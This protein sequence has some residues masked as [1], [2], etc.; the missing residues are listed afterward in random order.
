MPN[1]VFIYHW[2][3]MSEH[4]AESLDQSQMQ[5]MPEAMMSRVDALLVLKV[6]EKQFQVMGE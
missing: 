4:S 3:E 1:I 6:K 2:L 5:L